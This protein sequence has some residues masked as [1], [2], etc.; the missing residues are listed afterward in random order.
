VERLLRVVAVLLIT[1][2]I[3]VLGDVA[4]TLAWR[5]PVSSLYGS[6]QQHNLEGQLSDLERGFPSAPDLRRVSGSRSVRGTVDSLAHLF[7][8]RVGNGE[9]VGRMIIPAIDLDVVAVEGTDT[10]DLQKGPGHYPKT[11]FPGEGATTAFAGHRTTYLAPFRHLDSLNRGDE[12][13]VEMPYADLAYEVEKTKVVDPSD[14]RI[15]HP[16]SHERLVLTACNPLYSASQRIVV[17]ASLRQVS[18]FALGG[19]RWRDP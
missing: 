6:M 5:E 19:G 1:A 13:D 18:L 7:S 2:G 11:P 9:A 16:V 17:F 8:S 15:L 14:V 12:V 10:A 3:V 4:A